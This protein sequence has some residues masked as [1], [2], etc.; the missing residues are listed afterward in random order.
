MG[1]DWVA[2]ETMS[3]SEWGWRPRLTYSLG[4]SPR[5]NEHSSEVLPH[6]PVAAVQNVASLS[7]HGQLTVA[8]NDKLSSNLKPSESMLSL[9]PCAEYGLWSTYGVGG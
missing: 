4:N 2:S 7:D 5:A 6:A 1:T 9:P 8:D 3:E